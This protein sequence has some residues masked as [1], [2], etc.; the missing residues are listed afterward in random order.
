[1]RAHTLVLLT[2]G[3]GYFDGTQRAVKKRVDL[4]QL[5]GSRAGSVDATHHEGIISE[6]IL[7]IIFYEKWRCKCHLK[8][9]IS[10]EMERASGLE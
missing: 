8:R 9:I 1:V 3:S 6:L 10:S 2:H 5:S 4:Y 7:V